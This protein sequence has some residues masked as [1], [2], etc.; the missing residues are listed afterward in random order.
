MGKPSRIE[1][2]EVSRQVTGIA[3]EEAFSRV[4]NPGYG[5]GLV[6]VVTHGSS[7]KQYVGITVQ[8]LNRRWEYHLDQAR[9]GHIK[10]KRSLHA[11]IRKFGA[12]EFTIEQI[13]TGSSKGSLEAK[14]RKWIKELGTLIPDGFNISTKVTRWRNSANWV[15]TGKGSAHQNRR[16]K[17]AT[18][19]RNAAPSPTS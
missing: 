13:D 1:W 10:N 11:A 5:E 4:P 12:D 7:G 6:Y 17:S 18:F 16:P 8:S 19:Q 3:P 9:A 14:E 2:Y 15:S